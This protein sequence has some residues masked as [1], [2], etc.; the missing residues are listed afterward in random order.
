MNPAVWP[1]VSQLPAGK[2]V[3]IDSPDAVYV[4]KILE[5]RKEEGVEANHILVSYK[6]ATRAS[7]NVS[8]TKEEAKKLATE[9][10][11]GLEVKSPDWYK[12]TDIIAVDK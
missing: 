5:T 8:R 4:V 10:L 9:A 3:M 6:G 7:P 1:Q 11:K 12:A 2:L